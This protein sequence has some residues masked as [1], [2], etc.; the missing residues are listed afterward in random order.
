MK[1][2]FAFTIAIALAGM[3]VGSVDSFAAKGGIPGPPGGDE[4]AAAQ[5]LSVPTIMI[6]TPAGGLSCGTELGAPTDLLPPTGEPLTGYEVPGDYWVQKVHT[7]Q[8]QCFQAGSA[9]VWGN[10]GDNLEGDA[11]LK[12]GSPI[13]VEIVLTNE[14]AYPELTPLLGYT[15][16]KLEPSLLDRESAY[17]H[18]AV[19][20]EAGASVAV[21]IEF[22]DVSDDPLQQVWL[23]HDSQITFSVQNTDTGVYAVPPGTNPTAEINATGKVV[24]GYNLRV[25]VAGPYQIVFTSS[26]LVHFMGQDAVNGG[27]FDDHNA[28]INI[29]VTQ[30]GGGG[31]GKGRP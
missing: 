9:T 17:G 6:G 10:W 26:P 19:L 31:G 28:Y 21:P 7:W 18:E 8:A 3:L 20:V 1:R 5:N 14:D 2:T 25:G 29:N 30:G 15:V 27:L 12:V 24:Y 22:P 11:K 16:I 4:E 13:R 23:V